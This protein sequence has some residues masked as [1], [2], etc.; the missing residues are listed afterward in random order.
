MPSE[1]D[2]KAADDVAR[3]VITLFKARPRVTYDQFE[4]LRAMGC[5]MSLYYIENER[6]LAKG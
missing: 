5:D 4:Q 1:P 3:A 2:A 6:S